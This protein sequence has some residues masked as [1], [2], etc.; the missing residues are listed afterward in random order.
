MST[1]SPQAVEDSLKQCMDPEVPLNIVEMG[2]IYGID[3]A[4]NN[5]VN[6]KMT[7]TTQGC[8]LHETLVQDATRY[9]KKVPGVNNVNIDI[10]W[11]PPWTMDK[12]SEEAKTK[13][14]NMGAGMNTPAPINYE[15]ALPQGVGKISAA[16]RWF[17]G[18]S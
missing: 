5:D 7:M 15:T 12:M 17:N 11:D 6:I 3:V 2:L 1:V 14:K 4:D 8:P 13:I 16:R 18:F 9:V 10:V